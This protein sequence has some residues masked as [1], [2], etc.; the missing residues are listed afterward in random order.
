MKIK[1][2]PLGLPFWGHRRA[3]YMF[4]AGIGVGRQS[5]FMGRRRVSLFEQRSCGKARMAAFEAS[6]AYR[7][8]APWPHVAQIWPPSGVVSTECGSKCM[9]LLKHMFSFT[10][11]I[12]L[13]SAQTAFCNFSIEKPM[14]KAKRTASILDDRKAGFCNAMVEGHN[15]MLKLSWNR[16]SWV[17]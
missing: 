15:I 3:D 1:F 4:T 7:P 5:F 11:L 10:P 8:Q 16:V 9:C 6:D 17:I 2:R 13:S 12:T 14:D